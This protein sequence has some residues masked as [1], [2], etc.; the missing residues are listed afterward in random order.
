MEELRRVIFSY[1]GDG[2]P[3]P[4][5]FPNFF[6]QR[7]WEVIGLDLLKLI[8]FFFT[9]GCK[10]HNINFSWI[11]LIPKVQSPSSIKEFRPIYLLNCVYK[12]IMKLMTSRLAEVIG[13]LVSNSQPTFIRGRNIMDN[14]VC[15]QESILNISEGNLDSFLLKLDFKKAFDNVDWDFLFCIL[16][17]KG[18][19]ET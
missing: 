12:I 16:K 15:A 13:S 9:G 11:V 6:F 2:A 1:K 14:I 7:F 19:P 8:D 10:L 4:D 17:A 3:W 5:G 18:F